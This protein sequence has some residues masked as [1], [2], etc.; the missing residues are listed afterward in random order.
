MTSLTYFSHRAA[1]LSIAL[2]IDN[3]DKVTYLHVFEI[4]ME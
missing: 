4:R 2:K 1:L 3:V